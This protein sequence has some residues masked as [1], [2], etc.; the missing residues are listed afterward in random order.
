MHRQHMVYYFLLFCFTFAS[1]NSLCLFLKPIP[2]MLVSKSNAFYKKFLSS[3]P[4]S[5]C[6]LNM[7]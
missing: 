7:A 5:L 1:I 2:K 4:V 3:I 6:L